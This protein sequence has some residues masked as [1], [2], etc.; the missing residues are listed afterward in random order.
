MI[1]RILP[2]FVIYVLLNANIAYAGCKDYECCCQHT[3]D[4]GGT[5]YTCTQKS[6]NDCD[7]LYQGT[8]LANDKKCTSNRR[9]KKSG[10]LEHLMTIS[11]CDPHIASCPPRLLRSRPERIR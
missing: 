8:C 3:G 4:T 10:G 2:C 1:K 6:T 7:Y 9:M 5:V 11:L